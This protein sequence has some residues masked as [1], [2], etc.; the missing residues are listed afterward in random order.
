MKKILYVLALVFA[1]LLVSCEDF[2]EAP[3]QSTLDE[4]LIF[5]NPTLASMAVDGIK[6][7][8][9]ETNS[10]RGRYLTHYGGNSDIEWNNS[11]GTVGARPDLNRYVN[12]ATNT[13]MNTANNAWSM[14]YSG[15]ERANICIRGLR[16]FG[17]PQALRWLCSLQAYAALTTSADR[18]A[19]R[20]LSQLKR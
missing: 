1:G 12:S 6:V 18:G 13:D 17:N 2:L 9:G 10:Y 14:M 11:S 19:V 7:P 3:S 8:F 4:S 16:E 15:M 5:S 20:D